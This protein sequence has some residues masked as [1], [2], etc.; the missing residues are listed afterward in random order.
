VF[1][2]YLG[3]DPKIFTNGDKVTA[4]FSIGVTG[5]TKDAD[6]KNKTDWFNIVA[7]GKQAELVRDYTEKGSHVEVVGRAQNRQY[8]KDGIQVTTNEYVVQNIVFLSSPN[9]RGDSGTSSPETGGGVD[10]KALR[11]SM[12]SGEATQASAPNDDL[13]F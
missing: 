12:G 10:F 4:S 5:F 8:E 7:F 13:P 6:G 1:S 9:R 3:R 2:G 11:E